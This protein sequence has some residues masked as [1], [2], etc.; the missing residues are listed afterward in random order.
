MKKVSEG[1]EAVIYESSFLGIKAIVKY[2]IPK[3]YRIKQLDEKIRASRTKKEAR[4][5][6]MASGIV[7]TPHLLM[8]GKYNIWMERVDGTQLHLAKIKDARQR[9]HI[10]REMGI[11]LGKLHSLGITHGDYTTANFA[12]LNA[13]LLSNGLVTVSIEQQTLTAINIT[14]V[15]CNTNQTTANM[16]VATPAINLPIGG[17]ATF[18]VQCYSSGTAWNGPI[19]KILNGYLTI[20]YT[21][22]QSGLPHT[23][24]GQLVQKVV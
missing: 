7:R 23:I 19:N 12:C 20:N 18:S 13:Q 11:C 10:M 3:G 21:E 9:M 24:F 8:L 1:A 4:I 15:G 22:L 5:L 14:A 2:R 17:S 6:A 16:A